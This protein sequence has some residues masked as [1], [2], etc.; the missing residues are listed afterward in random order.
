MRAVADECVRHAESYI[1]LSFLPPGSLDHPSHHV[2]VIPSF[3]L[4]LLDPSVT[5][6]VL[7][8]EVLAG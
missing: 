6:S 1:Y 7:N 3:V 8:E 5:S 4:L 2:K